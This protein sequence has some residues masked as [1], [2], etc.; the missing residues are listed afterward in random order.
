MFHVGK[1]DDFRWNLVEREKEY[2]IQKSGIKHDTSY[3]IDID[4]RHHS[5]IAIMKK[6][7]TKKTTT[8][9]KIANNKVV[10]IKMVSIWSESAPIWLVCP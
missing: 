2:C 5:A 9:L 8:M 1:I 3:N 10:A 4:V 6:Q 7:T